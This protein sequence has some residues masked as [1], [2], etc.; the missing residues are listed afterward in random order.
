MLIEPKKPSLTSCIRVHEA[1][2][3]VVAYRLGGSIEYV[4]AKGREERMRLPNRRWVEHEG[5][6][7]THWFAD[8][9]TLTYPVPWNA[10]ECDLLIKDIC[11][12]L[13]GIWA[14][15]HY[16]GISFD[17]AAEMG[18]ATDLEMV[19]A[20]LDYLT[21]PCREPAKSLARKICGDTLKKTKNW[22]LVKELAAHLKKNPMVTGE[23][24]HSFL[25]VNKQ[26]W[27]LED[28]AKKMGWR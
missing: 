18:G 1:G 5:I 22:Y 14:H 24:V 9:A 28:A 6:C 10:P 13:G 11:V 4:G 15:K 23:K 17:E 19:D 7:F 20:I 27:Y 16:A 12:L 21:P 8:Y 25:D 2:H 26:L 3:A